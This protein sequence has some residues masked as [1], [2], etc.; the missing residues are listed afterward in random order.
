MQVPSVHSVCRH[1][2]LFMLKIG[3]HAHFSP[4]FWV[5]IMQH[6][7]PQEYP[8]MCQ[9]QQFQLLLCICK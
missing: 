7:R 2:Y 3:T 9:C 8:Q 1:V 5:F 6:N 4:N